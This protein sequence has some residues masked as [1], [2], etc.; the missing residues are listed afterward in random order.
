MASRDTAVPEPA[1]DLRAVTPGDFPN[2]A[3]LLA[4][5]FDF[6]GQ[7]PMPKER[8]AQVLERY[9]T[10]ERPMLEAILAEL[11]GTPVGFAIFGPVFWTGDMAPALF[12]EEIYVIKKHRGRRIGIALLRYLA[13]LALDRGWRRMIWH[14]DQPNRRAIQFYE[15]LPGAFRLSKHTYAVSSRDLE[16][17][18]DGA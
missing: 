1:L 7:A 16:R 5:S 9:G 4:D 3:N 10:G 17:L 12:L 14:V 6:Y 13:R 11:D 8:L 2:L 15:R 18:A